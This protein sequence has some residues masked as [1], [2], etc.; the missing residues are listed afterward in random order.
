MN[1][2][3]NYTSQKNHRQKM[4]NY[5]RTGNFRKLSGS[6]IHGRSVKRKR[7]YLYAVSLVIIIIGLSSAFL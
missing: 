4:T 3:V 7:L 6:P 1:Q 5:L 2:K